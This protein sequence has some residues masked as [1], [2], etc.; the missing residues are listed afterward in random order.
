MAAVA[1]GC[2]VGTGWVVTV[3]VTVDPDPPVV[4]RQWIDH[5][6][7]PQVIDRRRVDLVP[8]PA[9]FGYHEAAQLPLPAAEGSIA[10]VTEAARTSGARAWADIAATVDAA[11]HRLTCAA[12]I[13]PAAVPDRPL[14]QILASHA[15]IHTAEGA[16]YRSVVRSCCDT[17]S[18]PVENLP[19]RSLI[20]EVASATATSPD[21]ITTTLAALGRTLGP[22]WRREH[23]QA[24]LA[25]WLTLLPR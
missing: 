17:L 25:A 14:D 18:L 24:T 19:A 4:G 7:G 21:K 11:G 13:G 1:L 22:P 8:G 16:L 9:R 23:K 15:A 5:V 20:D 3:A 10:A 2:S 12:V 6:P